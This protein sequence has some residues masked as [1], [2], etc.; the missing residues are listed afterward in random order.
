MT[1]FEELEPRYMFEE[2][3]Y[4]YYEDEYF[5]RY[6]EVTEGPVKYQ[7]VFCK[8]E[9]CIEMIPTCEGAPHY[10]TRIDRDLLKAI[11]KQVEELEEADWE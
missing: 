8:Y 7:F 11:N 5:I 4:E 6:N 10:F 3:G 1:R 9:R 2:L